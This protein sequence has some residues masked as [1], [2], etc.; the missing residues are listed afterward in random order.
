MA[1]VNTAVAMVVEYIIS[2]ELYNFRSLTTNTQKRLKRAYGS[3]FETKVNKAL[4][5]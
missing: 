1:H 3:N 2:N 5:V 4:G